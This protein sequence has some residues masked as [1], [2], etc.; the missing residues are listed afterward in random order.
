MSIRFDLIAGRDVMAKGGNSR[1]AKMLIRWIA[2][3]THTTRV[4]SPRR[5]RSSVKSE[6][7][8]GCR[9]ALIDELDIVFI[10][11]FSPYSTHYKLRYLMNPN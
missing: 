9:W 8:T 6:I 5:R 11:I 10:M 3:G 4:K 2:P 7:G 1:Q